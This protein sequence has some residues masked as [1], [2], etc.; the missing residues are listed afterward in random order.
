[1]LSVTERL[2]PEQAASAESVAALAA[3]DPDAWQSL[4]ER[5]YD[6]MYR[7]AYVRTG[8]V[9]AAEE[10]AAEVFAAAV[11][12]IRK[13]RPTGAP[14]ASW[15]Y[16]IARNLTASHLDRRRRR[17]AVH[18]DGLELASGGWDGAVED[19]ADI[20]RAM[21]TL[22]RDQQDVL[23]LRFFSRCSL[24]ETAGAMGRSVGAVKVL[25]HRAIAAM[26]RRLTGGTP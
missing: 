14:L 4:F 21:S 13:Y 11:R 7:F 16:R 20:A 19:A 18:L 15:L 26:R 3:H 6:K 2:A 17:P 1:M 25:Q 24:E 5:Y 22:T 8:E 9:S 23:L 10:I 12:G